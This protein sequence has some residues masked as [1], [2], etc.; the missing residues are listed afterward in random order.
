LPIVILGNF[1][2]GRPSSKT[3]M[4]MAVIKP[5]EGGD[6]LAEITDPFQ[7]A[8]R[9][10][11]KVRGS[12][13]LGWQKYSMTIE[14]WD[15]D[16]LDRNI[17]P[18]DL[19]SEA[20]WV[21]NSKFQFDRALMRNDLAYRMSNDLGEY[22]PRT[23][24]V[25]VINNS[26]GGNLSYND[27]YF[28]V[29][30]LMEKIKR[31]KNRVNVTKILPTDN[32]EP[33]VSGGY[34]FKED[35]L[36]PEEIGFNVRGAG[37]LVHVYPREDDITSAQTTWLTNYLNEF[38]AAVSAA[39]WTHPSNGKHFT[40]Y[41]IVDSWIKHH[42]VNV[43]CMNVD[44]FRVSG[45][46]YKDRLGKIG[47]GPVWDF[48]RSM[49]STDDRDNNP[50][51][52]EG[53]DDS[54]KTWYDSR[55]PWWGEALQNSDFRQQHTDLWQTERDGGVFSWTHV[56]SMIDQFKAQLNTPVTNSGGIE[57]SAQARNFAKWTMFP[58]RNGGHAGEIAIL[59]NWLS[60]RLNWID[61][62]L[63]ERPSLA[64]VP[65]LV[66]E[67]TAVSFTRGDDTVYYTTDGSDPRL[68]GGAVSGRARTA[69]PVIVNVS[70]VIT[71]R[72]RS[73]SNWSGPI[74]ATYL[75]GSLANASNLVFTEI[76]YAP[77]SPATPGEQAVSLVPADYEFIELKNVSSTDRISLI[78]VHFEKGIDFAFTGSAIT[79]LGPG[80][81]VLIVSNQ[82]AFE[83][84]YG[85]AHSN[86]IAGEFQNG[87]RLDNDGETIRLVDALGVD[88]ALFTYNDQ[89]PW[90]FDAGF[91]GY[92]LVLINGIAPPVAYNNPALWRTSTDLGGNPNA[93]DHVPFVG[94]ELDDLDNDGIAALLE[95]ALGTSDSDS[96]AGAGAFGIDFAE[97][98]VA[99]VIATY[100]TATHRWNLAADGAVICV[101]QA[102]DLDGEWTKGGMIFHSEVHNGDGTSTVTYRGERPVSPADRR[103]FFRVAA[104]TR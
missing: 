11:M 98:E 76:H 49:D 44:G 54:S 92:S 31:D 74:Q 58:P 26:G 28:G 27:D 1:G 21:L 87:T 2:G 57:S 65:G 41:I 25:E 78:D 75:V 70:T 48:D 100:L 40:D 64:I 50:Q 71:A 91:A 96:G 14:A 13:S 19:P 32:T 4:F 52:W 20:D 33:R 10:T 55:F 102:D 59:K 17:D 60:T 62:Q 72:A 84:R 43:L 5:D 24:L 34:L 73:G 80:E 101:E 3:T 95:Y 16:N 79:S 15:G 82:A 22:A 63:T 35:R 39:N 61:T 83:A 93:S 94:N 85:V 88:I 30:S 29:Y 37:R 68:S 66:T 46:Y 36:D 103:M 51:A 81:R 56:E 90:P 47:A 89:A 23:R 45:Y 12:S 6:G 97:I 7:V 42:W 99:G 8:T 69:T 67:G 77:E 53:T 18:L 86:R 9:G 38:D 104:Q